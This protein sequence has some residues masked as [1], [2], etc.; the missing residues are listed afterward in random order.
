MTQLT[1]VENCEACSSSLEYAECYRKYIQVFCRKL[2]LDIS[3]LIEPILNQTNWNEPFTGC[4]WNNLGVVTLIESENSTDANLRDLYLE[5]AI[6]AFSQGEQTYPLC[7][8]HLAIIHSLLD[9]SHKARDIAF[10]AFFR[11]LSLTDSK[12]LSDKAPIGLIYIPRSWNDDRFDDL[13]ELILGLCQAPDANTQSQRLAC[14]CLWRSQLVFYNS[15]GLRFLHLANQQSQDSVGFNLRLGISSIVNKQWEGLQ[16][17]HRA[18]E[19]APDSLNVLHAL[20]LAYRDLGAVNTANTYL[21]AGRDIYQQNH[22]QSEGYWVKHREDHNF[23]YLKFDSDIVMAVEPSYQSIV[24]SVLMAEGDWFEKEMEF[25]RT[26]IKPGMTVIDVGANV[27]V[28][29]FSAAKQ[30]GAEGCVVAV[31]PF[32]GCVRYL[33]ETRKINKLDWVRVYAGAA[34]KKKGTAYLATKSASELNELITPNELGQNG[35]EGSEEVETFTLDGIC[36][37]EHLQK[38]DF[39]KIDAE[40]HELSV[41]S[42]SE[43]ILMEHKPIIL[44]ENIAGNHSS[45]SEVTNFLKSKGYGIFRYQSLTGDLLPIT[46]VEK[47]KNCLNLIAIK[48]DSE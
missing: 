16:Y 8:I 22:D 3:S 25:W 27:G 6:E 21:S 14:E 44:Y 31:E 12:S 34:S 39:L 46:S 47:Q 48:T 15:I 43:R 13:G 41:L 9:E 40:G 32:S 45:N 20:Y 5:M 18:R 10:K 19:K 28:Y 1:T 4:D 24:T 38:V 7:E 26:W 36:D 30:V 33:K 37:L 2:K 42:G 23:T 35:L 11:S 17:L 29:T